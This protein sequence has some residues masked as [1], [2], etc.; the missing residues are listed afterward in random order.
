LI[1]KKRDFGP[2]PFRK[3]VSPTPSSN[4][5]YLSNARGD[6]EIDLIHSPSR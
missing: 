1:L 2:W 5:F 4:K 3:G 6:K